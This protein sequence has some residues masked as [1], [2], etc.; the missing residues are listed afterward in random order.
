[1]EP[2]DADAASPAAHSGKQRNGKNRKNL[3]QGIWQ[4]IRVERIQKDIE[5]IAGCSDTPGEGATRPTFSPAWGKAVEYIRGQLNLADCESKS[6]AAGNLHARP[7]ELGWERQAWLCGSHIDTVPHGGDYDGVTGIVVALEL[8]RSAREDG[9]AALPL[10]LIIFAEEEGPTFGLGMIGSR[11]WVGE[12][13]EER[14]RALHNAQGQN[15]L[16]AGRPFGVDCD[17]LAKDRIRPEQYLGLVEVHIEQGPVMWR[18]DQRLAVVRAIAG[19]RQYSISVAGEAN[20]AGATPMDQRK[21]ALCGAAEIVLA[22]ERLA[23]VLSPDAVATVGR[24]VNYPNAI[25]VVADRVE[26]TVDLRAPEDAVLSRGDAEVRRLATEICNRRKLT[27]EIKMTEAIDACPLNARLCEK[28]STS[29]HLAG[30]GQ[31]PV[32]VSGALHDSAVLAPH[33][34]AAMLFVPSRGGIS[35]N[36]AEFS[37]VEDIAAAAKVVERLIR[38]PT[39][40]LLNGLDQKQFVAI[41]GGSFEHSPWIAERA[42]KS[43]PFSSIGD[44]HEKLT[45]VVSQS[46]TEEKLSLV[47]AHPDLVGKLARGGKLTHESTSEQTAAGL[48][49]LTPEEIAGFERFNAEYR[50]KFGFPFVICARQN[51]KEAILRAFP[52]RLA[53]S[54]EAELATALSEVFKIAQLRLADAVWEN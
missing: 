42:W 5:A 45:T 30:M 19:R 36:P 27:C 7:T 24:L 28:L 2:G 38:R 44:L 6:D 51:R 3:A 43:R 1:V 12:L 13:G 15:Y 23:P 9:N 50:G 16:D 47:N 4:V 10:E 48:A 32:T 18:N 49:Q 39:V 31:I 54:K 14:L 21:D 17:R 11:T 8:L 26:F 22:L 46:T 33:I 34:P 35:H 53:N 29:A 41:C 25:N 20:H 37:R 40:A 52:R